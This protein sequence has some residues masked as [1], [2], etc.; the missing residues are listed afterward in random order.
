MTTA[1]MPTREVPAVHRADTILSIE[2]LCASYGAVQVLRDVDFHVAR[3]EIVALLGTNGAG[4]STI[5]RC[6]SGLMRPDA[7]TIVLRKED[8]TEV[9]VA[10]VATEKTVQEGIVQVPGGR[11]LLPNL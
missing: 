8:G 3:G 10:H 9:D 6:I 4:K 1:E 5:L 11:G 7:G 2:G